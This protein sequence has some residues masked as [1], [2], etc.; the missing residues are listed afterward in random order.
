M[1]TNQHDA[2][3][4]A[5]AARIEALLQDWEDTAE[6]NHTGVGRAYAMCARDLRAAMVSE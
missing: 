6:R 5:R 4:E 1:D 3:T 2:D